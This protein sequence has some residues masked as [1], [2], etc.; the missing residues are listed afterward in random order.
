MLLIQNVLIWERVFHISTTI[1]EIPSQLNLVR[2]VQQNKAKMGGSS[3]KNKKEKD[4]GKGKKGKGPAEPEK[5]APAIAGAE[6]KNN[7]KEEPEKEEKNESV[8]DHGDGD[9]DDWEEGMVFASDQKKVCV[10]DFELLTVVGKGS[11]GKVCV[12]A[13]LF[14]FFGG[15]F[16]IL[17]FKFN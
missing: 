12:C 15:L 9:E 11:F 6:A 17:L 5:E 8:S 7:E 4:K 14:F 3:S 2:E 16:V 13:R 1:F 10:D